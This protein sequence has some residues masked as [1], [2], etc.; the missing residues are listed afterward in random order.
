[1]VK[2]FILQARLAKL[3]ALL[4]SKGNINMIWVFRRS[5]SVKEL[6]HPFLMWFIRWPRQWIRDKFSCRQRC[7]VKA[8]RSQCRMPRWEGEGIWF[9]WH[10]HRHRTIWSQP[11]Q[12][13]SCLAEQ[14]ANHGEREAPVSYLPSY[15]SSERGRLETEVSMIS[16]IQS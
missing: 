14:E 11:N 9:P 16:Q 1:M 4:L 8:W 15:P 12:V 3:E 13:S 7:S 6:P 10:C 2:S 5:M